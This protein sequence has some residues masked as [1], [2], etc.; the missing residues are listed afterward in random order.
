MRLVAQQ[1]AHVPCNSGSTADGPRA[2]ARA[3]ASK[4]DAV[5][6]IPAEARARAAAPDVRPVPGPRKPLAPAVFWAV[7]TLLGVLYIMALLCLCA[8]APTHFTVLLAQRTSMV[9]ARPPVSPR[10]MQF[11]CYWRSGPCCSHFHV[12]LHN[13]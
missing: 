2:R 1:R 6:D 9:R 10:R 5:I 11:L 3:Q 4:A 7:A 12:A 8:Y 13:G